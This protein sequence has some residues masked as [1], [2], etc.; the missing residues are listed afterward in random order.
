MTCNCNRTGDV[1]YQITLDAQGPQGR[2]GNAGPAGFSPIIEEYNA[3]DN[4]YQLKII[5]A[6]G[7]II[8]PNLK[9]QT[10]E[11][12]DGLVN[13]N[14]SNVFREVNYFENGLK[15]N[16]VTIKTPNYDYKIDTALNDITVTKTDNATGNSE[17]NIIAYKK[18]LENYVTLNTEQTITGTKTFNGVYFTKGIV[19]NEHNIIN[20]L[21]LYLGN[22][23]GTFCRI[24]RNE[25]LLPTNTYLGSRVGANNQVL[26]PNL[27]QAGEGIELT[28]ADK[29][30]I[31]STATGGASI[32][33]NTASTNTVYSSSK[34]EGLL[35][36]YVTT[37]TYTEAINNIDTNKQDKLIAGTGI[38]IEGNTISSQEGFITSS[39]A[40][41]NV[42]EGN[43]TLAID[44]QTIQV[45]SEGKLVANLDEVGN[46]LNTVANRVTSLETEVTNLSGEVASNTADIATIRGSLGNN[47]ISKLT[48]TEYSN[49]VTKDSNTLY[50]VVADDSS[51]FTMYYGEI[52]MYMPSGGGGDNASQK[53]YVA[54]MST[55][56]TAEPYT[57]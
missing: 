30:T 37:S 10:P 29:L 55:T 15:S 31:S 22:P 36:G 51:N 25:A 17:A 45:N 35:T 48:A 6:D 33:D 3:S 1:E 12:P 42:T 7:E 38:T 14:D 54:N 26:T 13:V 56:V 39:T 16:Y 41:L 53:T 5:L 47:L 50:I 9:G 43:L 57:A 2:Q 24:T 23:E 49:L 32:D 21:G 18:D 52:P 20:S 44:N 19:V 27:I 28:W 46:E 11:L 34:V 4:N 40:P 8:T